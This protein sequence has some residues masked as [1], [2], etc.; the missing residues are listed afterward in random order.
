MHFVL[1]V[2]ISIW[3]AMSDKHSRAGGQRSRSQS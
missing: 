3:S 2:S 1:D